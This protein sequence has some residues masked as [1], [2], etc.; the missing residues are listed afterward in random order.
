MDVN[1]GRRR[2]MGY[3]LGYLVYILA[4]PSSAWVFLGGW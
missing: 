2:G 4:V 3:L 1:I